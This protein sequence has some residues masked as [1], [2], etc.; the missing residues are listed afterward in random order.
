MSKCLC[1]CDY[2]SL[3]LAAESLPVH[4]I[5]CCSEGK[6]YLRSVEPVKCSVC[7][8]MCVR[9]VSAESCVCVC[10]LTDAGSE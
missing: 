4:V 2:N 9:A 6:H 3:G 1:V 7:V 8:C 10:V 5:G